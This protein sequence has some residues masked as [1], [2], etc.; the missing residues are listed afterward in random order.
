[1]IR[2]ASARVVIAVV[3]VVG[4]L[5]DQWTKYLAVAHLDPLNPPVFLGGFVTLRLIRNPGAAFSLGGDDF[6]LVFTA[7][8]AVAI[9]VVLVLLVPRVR[10]LSWAVMTGLLL[11]GITG[12]FIDRLIREPGFLRGHVVDFVQ[13]PSFAIFNVADACLTTAAVLIIVSSF[14]GSRDFDGKRRQGA[15][16][17]PSREP[18]AAG[19]EPGRSA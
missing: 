12:N 6:T 3:A 11:A 1:M 2:A 8:A 13:L 18:G 19:S 17:G 9:Q 4:V 16:S 14:V 7:L 5:L 15:G 10:V